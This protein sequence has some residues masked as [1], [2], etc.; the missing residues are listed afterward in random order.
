MTL[1]LR[2][3]SRKSLDDLIVDGIHQAHVCNLD[4]RPVESLSLAFEF[5]A[6]MN[7]RLQ[8]YVDDADRA[9]LRA[10]SCQVIVFGDRLMQRRSNIVDC[11]AR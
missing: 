3:R 5:R 10:D 2:C 11:R 8:D 7:L 4:Y 6:R 9:E 1:S